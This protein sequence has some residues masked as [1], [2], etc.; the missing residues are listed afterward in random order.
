MLAGASALGFVVLTILVATH[1]TQH[2]DDVLRDHARPDD[3]WGRWQRRADRVVSDLRPPFIATFLAF[4]GI[5][6][7][8]YRRSWR[9]GGYAALLGCAAAI[10]TQFVKALLSRPDPYF[11][12]VGHSGSFPSGHTVSLIVCLGG[13][14]LIAQ[15]QTR[16]W[17]WIVPALAGVL[18]AWSLVVEG[19]HWATDVIGGG[20]LA[21]AILAVGSTIP[22]RWAKP[23]A[24]QRTSE[25]HPGGAEETAVNGVAPHEQAG[26]T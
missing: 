26:Q 6:Y 1:T 5:G 16:W 9:P 11:G 17:Q 15:A 23:A 21:V 8:L 22:L 18:M 2:L 24:R 20:L 13:G 14:L 12:P 4:V 19:V 3:V 25:D 7:S 10:S